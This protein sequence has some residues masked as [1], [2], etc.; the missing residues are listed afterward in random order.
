MGRYIVKGDSLFIPFKKGMSLTDSQLRP[1]IYKTM[2]MVKTVLRSWEVDEI[3][4]YAEVVRCK[5]CR[6]YDPTGDYCG[7]WGGVRHPEHFCGE[8]DRESNE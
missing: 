2:D 3:A 5:D 7:C 4:E 6:Y 8:G 1:R